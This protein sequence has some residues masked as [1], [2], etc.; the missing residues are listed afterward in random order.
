MAWPMWPDAR[1]DLNTLAVPTCDVIRSP[2]SGSCYYHIADP[3]RRLIDPPHPPPD[4]LE[5]LL[6]GLLW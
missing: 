2:T 5:L 6:T 3:P 4:V 1:G